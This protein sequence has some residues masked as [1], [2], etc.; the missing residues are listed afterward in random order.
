MHPED[1]GYEYTIIGWL[2]REE[3]QAILNAIR[4]QIGEPPKDYT[5]AS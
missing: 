2:S 3:R 4:E 1:A 5:R